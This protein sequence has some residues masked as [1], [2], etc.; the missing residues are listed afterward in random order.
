MK[1]SF[2]VFLRTRNAKKGDLSKALVAMCSGL[3]SFLKVC[4]LNYRSHLFYYDKSLNERI[5][6]FAN[7]KWKY[8]LW[9]EIWWDMAAL[10]GQHLLWY[11]AKLPYLFEMPLFHWNCF[12]TFNLWTSWSV[13]YKPVNWFHMNLVTQWQNR[14]NGFSAM[15]IGEPF[16]ENV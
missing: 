15:I 5:Y 3:K 11:G 6:L 16:L 9:W 12:K 8:H 7:V 1:T 13:I 2:P 14:T 4:L 10:P